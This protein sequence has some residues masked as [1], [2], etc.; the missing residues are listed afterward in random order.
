MLEKYS[1]Y[2]ILQEFF[3][4]PL[5]R[6][7]L[8]ELSRLT[9]ISLPSVRN[10]V[11]ALEKD[12][13]VRRIREGVYESYAAGSESSRFRALKTMDMVMRIRESGFLEFLERELSYPSAIVLFGSCAE[14]TDNENSDVDIFI[15][16]KEAGV[17]TKKYEKK[18]GRSISL[19]FMSRK[20]LEKA[21]HDSPEFLNNIIN[22]IVLY[23]YLKVL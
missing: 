12:G 6:F 9:G 14:G 23:G 5:H 20:V 19:H 10:H 8:R 13:L 11:M 7:Q 1:R 4:R 18:L 16:G 22:G 2:R 3:D 15:L 21:K 17:N